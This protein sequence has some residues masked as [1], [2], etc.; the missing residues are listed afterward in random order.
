MMRRR[1]AITAIIASGMLF[2]MVLMIALA[3]GLALRQ[4]QESRR[5]GQVN[6]GNCIA[7]NAFRAGNQAVWANFLQIALADNKDPRAQAKAHAI[8]A[9]VNK[10]DALRNCAAVTK[11]G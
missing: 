11:A 4:Q 6:M 7:G 8:M 2:I 5:L 9:F 3:V 10:T 1:P